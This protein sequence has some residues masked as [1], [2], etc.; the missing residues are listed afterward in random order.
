MRYVT[1]TTQYCGIQLQWVGYELDMDGE[2]SG[3]Q[4]LK[5][6]PFTNFLFID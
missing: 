3:F 6:P 1:D 4:K 2:T 5:L